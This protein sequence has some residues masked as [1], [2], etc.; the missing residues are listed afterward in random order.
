[1]SDFWEGPKYEDR[2][3]AGLVLAEQLLSY[4]SAKPVILAIP[5]GGVAVGLP[6]AKGLQCPLHLL[7]VRRS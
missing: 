1:M 4:K 7:V 5:N 2:Y 6:I 3:D